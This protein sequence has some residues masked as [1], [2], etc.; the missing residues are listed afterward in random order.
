MARRRA[1]VKPRP[2]GGARHGQAAKP[3]AVKPQRF[4]GGAP[5]DVM[6]PD[7]IEKMRKRKYL[8]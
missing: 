8:A 1:R 5:G 4:Y 6:H 2:F 3:K 7:V